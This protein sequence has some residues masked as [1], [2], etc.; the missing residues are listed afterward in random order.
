MGKWLTISEAVDVLGISERA[1]REK[2]RNQKIQSKLEE[3]R[4][5]V[6]V[7]HEEVGHEATHEGHHDLLHEKDER[8]ADLQKQVYNLQE[9][10]VRRDNQVESL[11]EKMDHLTQV[12]AMAQKNVATLTDQLDS[13]HLVIEDLRHRQPLWKRLFHRGNAETGRG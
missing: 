3:K 2:V 12:V 8:I 5:Y 13:S 9:Q 10:L 1:L 11:T 6:W 4:R 7:E